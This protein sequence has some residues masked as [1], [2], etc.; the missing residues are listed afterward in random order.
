MQLI[1]RILIIAAIAFLP[2]RLLA[3]VSIEVFN[4]TGMVPYTVL[5]NA[6]ESTPVAGEIVSYHW[7]FND[8]NSDYAET[9]EGRLVG[10]RFDA[11]GVYT[12]TL[13]VL[14]SA[15]NTQIGTQSITVAAI[16]ANAVIYYVA[17]NGSDSN[18]G[19]STGTPFLTVSHASSVLASAPLGSSVLFRRGDTFTGSWG[20]SSILK[21]GPYF[22]KVGAYGEGERPVI[23]GGVSGGATEGLGIILE[24]LDIRGEIS[25]WS[26]YY[27]QTSPVGF[28]YPGTKLILR[29]IKAYNYG[30]MAG[31][32]HTIE[33][34]LFDGQTTVNV[35]FGSSGFPI[36]AKWL[37]AKNLEVA[38]AEGHAVY[39]AE[40]G[41]DILLENVNF[42]HSGIYGTLRDGITIHGQF[43]NVIVRGG[44]IHNNGYAF[45]VDDG[46][47]PGH[48][49]NPEYMT[50]FIFENLRI[51]DQQHS[52]AQLQG[53][54]NFIFRNNIVYNNAQ[55]TMQ[56][57]AIDFSAPNSGG[58][59]AGNAVAKFYN[60][61]FYNQDGQ[62]TFS[63]TDSTATGVEF[64]NNII[65]NSSS[66]YDLVYAANPS[67][68]SFSNNLYYGNAGNFTIGGTARSIAQWLASGLDPGAVNSD[69]IFLDSGGADFRVPQNSSAVDAGATV[70]ARYDYLGGSRPKGAS[71]DIGAY[72][73]DSGAGGLI[74]CYQD[75][76]SDLYGHGVSESVSSC[77]PSYYIS[78][79]FV[80][81]TGDCNDSSASI[82]PGAADVCPADGIDQDCS[83]SDYTNCGGGAGSYKKAR[84]SAGLFKIGQKNVQ[85]AP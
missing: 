55:P 61:V 27:S 80:S 81:L 77:S 37:Y 3:A 8:S 28:R 14:D 1:A 59:D 57:A 39:L 45:G 63:L 52:V 36:G 6:K 64:K 54:Q 16:P 71:F 35:S 50:N 65:M 75:A 69:P 20:I 84:I 22:Y 85:I 2:G 42:H 9:D 41:E 67:N 53:V 31:A 66:G 33:N 79:H 70:D 83:G 26:D 72:E 32:G 49:S 68:I 21:S 46:Y 40:F 15:G 18:N 4:N 62:P 60:N 48:Y 82:H 7:D 78:S 23:A 29:G 34:C 5:F 47:I 25:V 56:R 51:Y 19:T 24:N 30:N 44:E 76:D 38:R 10:H 58:G 13:S 11:P 74:T 73:Y 17:S 12:V 43:E